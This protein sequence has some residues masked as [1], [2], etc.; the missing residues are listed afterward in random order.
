MYC[1]KN[2]HKASECW[3]KRADSERT[4]SGNVDKR[5][6]QRS[7]YA[8]G[9]GKAEKGSTFVMRHKVN[10]MKQTTPKLDEVWYV[11]SGVLNHMTCHKELFSYLE[12]PMQPGV[13]A[14]RDDTPHPIANVGVVSLSHVE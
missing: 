12:K 1:G 9:S 11:D 5:N 14:I 7:H 8:E 6:Q 2:G 4:G 3:K 13:V 10:Y